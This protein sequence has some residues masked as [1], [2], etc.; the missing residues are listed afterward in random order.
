MTQDATALVTYSVS[1][2]WIAAARERY[3]PLT[4]DT[5][6]G[7][8]E[9]RLAIGQVREKRTEIEKRRVELKADALKFGRFVDSEA[10][11]YTD[12]LLEIEEPL[13]EKKAA[14]DNE[15]V[16]VKAEAEAE[17]LRA[18]EAEIAAHRARQ[19]AE[20]K[21]VRNA[22]EARLAA[23]RVALD[24]ERKLLA[25]ERR[26]ADEAAALVRA[27]QAAQMQVERARLA[28]V[29]E[30]QRVEREALEAERRTVT[31]EREKAARVE[32][33]RQAKIKAEAEAVA[34]VERDRL[35]AAEHK[36]KLDAL[37]PD[38]EKLH[39]FA[40]SI[41]SLAEPKLKSKEAKT[42]MAVA[43]AQLEAVAVALDDAAAIK[44]AVA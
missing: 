8:E 11:R 42:R 10:K 44:K 38:I 30:A 15:A 25:E 12:L 20:L 27:E 3:L 36:A 19:E 14:I 40:A 24:A 32:F 1:T 6:K 18:I 7:Y 39:A 16:R 34:K 43:L 2:E 21:A 23:E 37:A 29:E 9:V 28:K 13:K 22:E 35:A 17:K 31:T 41:R 33:E 26:K 4:A 5:P